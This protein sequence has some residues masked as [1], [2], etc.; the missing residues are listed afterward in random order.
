MNEIKIII[1]DQEVA[2]G[3]G[4]TILQAATESGI[5]IPT[6]CF[7]PALQPSGSCRLCAVEIEGARGLPAACSTP[8]TAG[9]KIRTNTVKVEDFRR[10]M[11][12]IILQDHPREC[13]ACPRNGTCELQQLV[14]A[15]GIDFPYP[16]PAKPRPPALPAGAYFERDYS[17]CVR[18]GRCVRICHEVRGARAIVFRERQGRQ[19]VGTPFDLPLEHAGCQFCGACLDVCPTGALR[20][21][22]RSFQQEPRGHMDQV[23]A[24]LTNIVMSLYQKEIEGVWKSA[25]CPMCSAGCR[26]DFELTET[27]EVMQIK[28]ALEGPSNRGQACVQGRFLLKGYAQT[29]AR[30]VDPQ[31]KSDGG[32]QPVAMADAIW[33]A[34]DQLRRFAPE[35]RAVLTDGRLTNE[36]LFALA[37]FADQ[38]LGTSAIGCLASPG[39]DRVA[40]ALEQHLGTAAA[41]TG[42]HD[43]DQAGAILAIGF[44]PAATHPIIG[45]AVRGAVLKGTRLVVANPMEIAISRYSDVPLRHLPGTET[46]LVL[47]LARALL[48]RGGFDPG[49]GADQ[50]ETAARFK[51]ALQAYDLETVAGICGVSAE[52]LVESACVL[53]NAGP[54]AIL[55]G[56]GLLQAAQPEPLIQALIGLVWARGGFGKAG[57]GLLPAYGSCNTQGARDLGFT[58]DVPAQLAAGKIKALY[59]AV[60]ALTK[61]QLDWLQPY[62]KQVEVVV[63]QGTSPPAAGLAADVLL[64]LASLLEKEGSLTNSERRVQWT[65]PVFIAPGEAR[66][67][68]ETLA[69]MAEVIGCR[70]PETNPRT[71][72]AAIGQQHPAYAGI[73]TTRARFEPVQ[74]PCPDP[75]HGGSPVLFADQA[76]TIAIESWPPLE[77][78]AELALRDQEFTF[79]VV[80]KETLAPFWQ[81]PLLAPEAAAAMQNDGAIEMNPADAY[82]RGYQPGDSVTLTTRAGAITG[83]LALNKR[84][85]VKMIAVPTRE[86]AAVIGAE[87]GPGMVL[88]AMVADL[89]AAQ[90]AE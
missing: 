47:G 48:D 8:V 16:P 81:G 70:T 75:A 21:N 35:Q 84:L 3:A 30:L 87:A 13:L 34:A 68:P 60:E 17:L 62:L 55:Y 24:N 67:L 82:T 80:A 52:D 79:A 14:M 22:T 38:V 59:L 19:E 76:P 11:L 57:G 7:H 43:L 36:E 74:W 10:E 18:C 64:P 50:P 45:T 9:M 65:E 86:L 15:V 6:L 42:W 90:P 2:V 33:Q 66:S 40:R 85:P 54:L 44:N 69:A 53:S 28:P 23:C 72:L 32:Y 39:H 27:D 41:T 12:R 29:G 58:A 20:E 56:P 5:H 37:D 26:L 89:N 1:N 25:I 4:R 46:T 77:R 49:F 61:D 71:L 78:P 83:R 31:V 73:T 88:A 63:Y 51:E